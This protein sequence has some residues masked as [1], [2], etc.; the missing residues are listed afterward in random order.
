MLNTLFRVL[1]PPIFPDDPNKTRSAYYINV[2]SLIGMAAI[3]L[4]LLA[5]V[6]ILKIS[7]TDIANLIIIG[8]IVALGIGWFT[9]R[10]G[11]VRLAGYITIILIWIGSTFLALTGS[12]LRGSGF[13]S[14]FV[15]IILA[16]LLVGVRAAV[17]VSILSIFSAFGLAYIESIGRLADPADP[18]FEVAVCRTRERL[19]HPF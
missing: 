14:Y 4:L 7:L 10:A 2:V 6:F 13:I 5:Q 11:A 3:S 15:I 18:P 19:R 1:A 16:G 17:A 8:I 12:G 9:M